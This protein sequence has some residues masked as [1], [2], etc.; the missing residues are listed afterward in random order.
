MAAMTPEESANATRVSMPVG[1]HE[2]L[3]FS[4]FSLDRTPSG[5]V[6]CRVTLEFGPGEQVTGLVTGQASPAG[7]TRLGAEAA[8]RALEIF[9]DRSITFELIGVKVVRAFDANVVIT[10]LK[11]HGDAGPD[12]LLGCYLAEGDMVRGAALS[13]LNA[14]NRVLG[15]YFLT[16]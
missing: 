15:T 2:R 3:R 9:T 10:S 14:T 13:V 8:I 6:T 1:K 16:R 12:R 7:D 4:S 5:N 11:Q